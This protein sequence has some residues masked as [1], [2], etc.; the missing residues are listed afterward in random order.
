MLSLPLRRLRCNEG[1]PQQSHPRDECDAGGRS[2]GAPS[3]GRHPHKEGFGAKLSWMCY[4]CNLD[5]RQ[6]D[7]WATEHEALRGRTVLREGT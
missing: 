6:E 5:R 3:G 1:D 4:K 7:S 2:V